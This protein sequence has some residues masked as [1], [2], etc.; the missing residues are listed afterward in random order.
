MDSAGNKKSNLG[1]DKKT[2][3]TATN[4]VTGI[5]TSDLRKPDKKADLAEQK[6]R[7]ES[8][9]RGNKV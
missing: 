2:G 5:T 9:G 4:D 8:Q 6:R 1:N 7:L 3:N